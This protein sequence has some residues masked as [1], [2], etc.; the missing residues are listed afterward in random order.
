MFRQAT[1]DIFRR[2]LGNVACKVSQRHMM[3]IVFQLG[4]ESTHFAE[5]TRGEKPL[6]VVA[7]I[8]ILLRYPRDRL[9]GTVPCP[10]E[11][12][13]VSRQRFYQLAIQNT[14]GISLVLAQSPG[15]RFNEMEA[16]GIQPIRTCHAQ[17]SDL[18]MG[19]KD[20]PHL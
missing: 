5:I 11:A 6:Q 10:F 15:Q 16:H 7:S 1:V 19:I 14:F 3:V 20:L 13:P 2:M 17:R 18:H 12:S 9:P 8:W 4:D